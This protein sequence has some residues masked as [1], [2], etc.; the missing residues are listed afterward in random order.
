M[1]TKIV[2]CILYMTKC[3]DDR[4]SHD[5]S[6]IGVDVS[7]GVIVVDS[8]SCL[9]LLPLFLWGLSLVPVYCAML[10]S[11]LVGQSYRWG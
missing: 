8:L 2:L 6:L 4:Q 1:C 3:L 5:K 11:L 7:V 10:V 9:L